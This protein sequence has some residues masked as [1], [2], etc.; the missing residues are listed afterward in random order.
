MGAVTIFLPGGV[1][2]F[3]AGM[4]VGVYF[5]KACT[6]ILDEIYGKGA[7]GAILNASGYV[8][9]LTFNLAEYYKR[10]E[11][12]NRQTANNIARAKKTQEEIERNFDIFEKMKGE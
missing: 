6:N 7:Y 8:Y 9:G 12:N 2:G 1:L 4:A 11:Q 10:I 3:V 5:N